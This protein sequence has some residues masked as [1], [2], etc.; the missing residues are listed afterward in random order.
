MREHTASRTTAPF[1][2]SQARW[3]LD[4]KKGASNDLAIKA[5]PDSLRFVV[6]NTVV[7]AISRKNIDDVAGQ[8]GF[9]VNHNLDVRVTNYMVM[10]GG[11]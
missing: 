4:D 9:R 3:R 7:H 2:R 1:V 5:G 8:V 6:N 11:K 10:K